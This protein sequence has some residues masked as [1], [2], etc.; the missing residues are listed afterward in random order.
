L[1]D[2]ALPGSLPALP[3]PIPVIDLFAGPGGL[4]EGFSQVR[5][6]R[7]RRVFDTRV[8]VEFEE[9][10]HRTLELR[11]LY[12]LLEEHGDKSDYYLYARRK[13]EREELF[14]RSGDLGARAAREAH[15]ATLGKSE[16][17]NRAIEAHISAQLKGVGKDGCVLIGGPPCQAYS[18]VGRA[19]RAKETRTRFEAD[20]RHVLYREYL[21]IVSRFRPAAFLMENVPGLLSASL[22]GSG[23]FDLIRRDLTDAGYDLHPLAEAGEDADNPR[24][25]VIRADAHG[26]P[27]C[28]SRV[29]ILGLRRDLGLKPRVLAPLAGARTS[30]RDVLDD[31]PKIRSKLS[32]EPDSGKAWLEA[33]RRVGDYDLDGLGAGFGRAVRDTLGAMSAGLPVGVPAMPATGKKPGKLAAWYGD[34]ELG[35]V[36]NH[37]SR[38]HMRRDLARYFFW[39]QYGAHFGRSPT[40][41]DVPHYLRPE[42]RNAAGDAS[43]AP[44]ADRFRVQLAD[45]PSTTITSHIAKDGHYYIHHDPEQSRSLTVRE[46]AR[47]Q[48]FPDNYLFEG[49]VTDQYRQVGNAV[50]PYLAKQIG[51]L[52]ADVLG[53]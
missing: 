38:G 3:M 31:L 23:T 45:R 26:A 52:V 18:L 43:S 30:V 6:G 40:L 8:S 5:D 17:D 25:Y 24:R 15:R 53:A 19:R 9:L 36:L 29:F 13:I 22:N 14:A 50:P 12:R 42:H 35:C 16:A 20:H 48:T 32:K 1:T 10:A 51:R 28:R 21:R 33:V 49:A 41:G 4:N 11:A 27:Q 37:T 44:F 34:A 39:S 2:G 47:L 7:G 46:A